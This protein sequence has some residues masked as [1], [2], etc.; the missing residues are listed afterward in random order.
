MNHAAQV[1]IIGAKSNPTTG[2]LWNTA[3]ITFRPGKFVSVYDPREIDLN[4]LPP[5]VQAAAKVAMK[6]GVPKA[7][8]CVGTTCALPTSSPQEEAKLIRTFGLIRGKPYLRD[9]CSPC[10]LGL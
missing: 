6:D 9:S 1:V 10:P 8:V 3:L 2:K 4:R 5:A 7:Y